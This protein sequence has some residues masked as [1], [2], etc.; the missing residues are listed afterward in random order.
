MKKYFGFLLALV[1][2]F[3]SF[4]F[5]AAEEATSAEWNLTIMH[6]N[7][8][9]AHLDSIAKR[10]T[11]VNEIR[12]EVEN[13]IL[14]DAGD[15]FNG[16]LFFN[17]YLGKADLDFMNRLGYDAM[18]FGNHEFDKTSQVLA[19]FVKDAKFPFVSSN[20]DFTKDAD[21]KDLVVSGVGENPEGGKIYNTIILDVNGEKIGIIGLTTLETLEI[22]S[23]SK[24]IVFNDYI[25]SAEAAKAQLEDQGI[26]KIVV[27]SHLGYYD[28]LK[29]AEAV[30]GLDVIVGGHTHTKLDEPV[31]I[32]NGGTTL[33]VQAN[34]WGK[35]LG[36]VDVTFNEAGEIVKYNGKLIEVDTDEVVADPEIQALLEEYKGPIEEMKAEVVGYTTVKLDGER[37]DVRSRETNLGNMVAD[38]FLAKASQYT[39]ATIAIINGGGLRASVEAGPITLGDVRTVQPFENLLVTVEMTGEQIVAALEN[40]V[41]QVEEFAGRFPQV[42]GLK[43]TYDPSKPAGSRVVSVEVKTD[44]GYAPIDPKASYVVATNSY[45]ATGGDGYTS[46]NEATLAGKKTDLFYVDYEIIVEYLGKFESVSPMVE[47]RIIALEPK[48]EETKKEDIVYIVKSGD[49]LWKIAKKY[50]YTYQELAAYNN[51]KNPHLI[52]VGQKILIPVK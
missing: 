23:P 28:D 17:K 31:V 18:T 7:D 26:N 46:M 44:N 22:A 6:T 30:S 42:S 52:F 33:V 34:E 16:T 25:A 4:S 15:V 35:Y 27:L 5:V 37:N 8:T 10:F 45:M 47:G 24:D 11:L 32:N 3:Q 9:H 48:Q 19:D 29:L 49:V 36:R 13:S 2:L 39:N 41:S 20:I 43:F 1:L 40:G 12:A 21:L 14:V 50:G 51:I 38:A